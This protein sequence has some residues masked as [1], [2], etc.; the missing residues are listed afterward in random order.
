MRI[1]SFVV[2]D[3]TPVAELMG[4]CSHAPCCGNG[5]HAVALEGVRTRVFGVAKGKTREAAAAAFVRDVLGV[6]S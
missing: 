1:A 5:W 4:P 2:V 6:E 3:G